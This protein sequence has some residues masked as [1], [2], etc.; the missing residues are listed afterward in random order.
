MPEPTRED[1]PCPHSWPGSGP[2]YLALT[3]EAT[4]QHLAVEGK[5]PLAVLG[6]A[7]SHGLID[8][9]PCQGVGH[10]GKGHGSEERDRSCSSPNRHICHPGFWDQNL[11]VGRG[12]V[13]RPLEV[14]FSAKE[15]KRFVGTEGLGGEPKA[16]TA[17]VCTAR[18]SGRCRVP[19]CRQSAPPAAPCR[20]S[21]SSPPVVSAGAPVVGWGS[22]WC[23]TGR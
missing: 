5:R 12:G 17:P 21:A 15:R 8:G 11:R 4:Q 1:S 16:G 3:A 9:E 20:S 7:V 13:G 19:R 6:H 10:L 18:R 23:R 2:S 14:D 22:H